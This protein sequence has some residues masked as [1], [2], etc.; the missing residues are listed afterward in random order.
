MNPVERLISIFTP[1]SCVLC[2]FEGNP[3]CRECSELLPAQPSV[4]FV[5]GK[6]TNNF[7]TCPACISRFKPQHVWTTGKYE[8]Q[9][10][11]V[12]SEY[13]FGNLRSL[14]KCMSELIDESLPFFAEPPLVTYVPTSSNHSRQRGFDHAKLLAKELAKKTWL[15]FCCVTTEANQNQAAGCQTGSTQTAI[16]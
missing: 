8:S 2:E 3:L 9:A 16:S 7:K 15:A 13:K 1:Y 5:C 10:R 6:A 12:I 11:L 14:A 4:C